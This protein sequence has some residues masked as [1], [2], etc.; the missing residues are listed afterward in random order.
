MD[1]SALGAGIA[2]A[3]TLLAFSAHA[4]Q[5]PPGALNVR[6]FGAVGD[7]ETD[8]TAAFQKAFAAA[9]DAG[10]GIVHAPRGDYMIRGTL[11]VPGNVVLEG[12]W[13]APTARTQNQG[14][15]LLAVAGAGEP[16]GRPFLT[17]RANSTL[18]GLTIFY[19]EQKFANPP[20]AYP[21]TVRGIGDNCSLVD[22]LMVNPYQAV[23]FGTH[24][25]GR[26]YIRGLYAQPLYRGLFIDQCYDVGRVQDVHF[27]PFWGTGGGIREF[28]GEQ[29]IAFVIGRTDWQYMVNCFS[30]FYSIGFHFVNNGHGGG[31]VLLTQCGADVGPVAVRVDEVQAHSGIAFVNSQQMAGVEIGPD[32]AGP[33]KFTNCGF[34]PV[35][36]TES[37]IVNQGRGTVTLN[38]CHFT[39]WDQQGEGAPCIDARAGRLTVTGCEF[40]EG[41]KLQIR[42]GPDVEGAVITGNQVRGPLLIQDNSDGKAQIGLNAAEEEAR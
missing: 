27:W 20:V 31:N 10:G 29:G 6:D 15:T 5:P 19:P 9:A 32:N 41:G 42:L 23:D 11:E 38:A 3:A 4:Q 30:I 17:L 40:L 8:D 21:W 34:W 33:V 12:V 24:T 28:M 7:G 16:D 1:T 37:H 36:T 14:T 39:G 22:V 18:H 25:A 2:L 26:H 13:R 35:G